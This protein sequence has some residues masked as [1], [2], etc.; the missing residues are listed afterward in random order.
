MR[1]QR[2]F[3]SAVRV[4]FGWLD[5]AMEETGEVSEL[6]LVCWC[7]G[8]SAAASTHLSSQDSLVIVSRS[9]AEEEKN[10]ELGESSFE[11]VQR[12]LS[13]L[14]AEVGQLKQR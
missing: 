6:C 7:T 4:A 11:E 8:Y 14:K 3:T 12:T 1:A 13:A 9:D 2:L 10:T 5:E